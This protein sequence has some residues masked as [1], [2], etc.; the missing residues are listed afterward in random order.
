MESPAVML[1]TGTSRGLGLGLAQHYSNQGFQV[2]GCSRSVAAWNHPHYTHHQVDVTDEQSVMRWFSAV[3]RQT[4]KIDVV[5]HNAGAARMN[6]LLTT[7]V[8]TFD[9]LMATNARS[10]FLVTREAGKA[11]MKSGG[12]ILLMT[13]VAVPL[14][15]EGETVY[16]MSKAAVEQLTRQAAHEFSSL[17]V[18]VNAVGPGPVKTDLVGNVPEEK[19]SHLL[20]RLH[21]SDFQTVQDVIQGVEMFLTGPHRHSSGEVV[22]LASAL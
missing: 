9:Q 15:L 21:L 8:S 2:F 10:A 20:Q 22:Y 1:I 5:I 18:R 3:R 11:M 6:H 4:E 19:M 16:S 14:A 7:P 17:G 13:T 12:L